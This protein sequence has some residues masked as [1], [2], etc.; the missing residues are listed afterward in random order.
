MSE[1]KL[2][3]A[4][5][6]RENL[7]L[8]S[9]HLNNN[10]VVLPPRRPPVVP[11]RSMITTPMHGSHNSLLQQA[12]SSG[13]PKVYVVTFNV[14]NLHYIRPTSVDSAID[15]SS[16]SRSSLQQFATTGI[17]HLGQHPAHGNFR[18]HSECSSPIS[19]STSNS[20]NTD[21]QRHSST[22]RFKCQSDTQT[23]ERSIR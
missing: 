20:T 3:Q 21:D 6:E 14:R 16:T 9:S 8:R 2:Q 23:T 4:A 18:Q 11:A 1:L 10:S 7:E 22:N 17:S 5:L 19:S 13:S 15:I 12:S